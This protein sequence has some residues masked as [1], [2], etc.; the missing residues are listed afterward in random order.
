MCKTQINF[1]SSWN[2][3]HGK[4]KL[5]TWELLLA[6]F[7]DLAYF[8]SIYLLIKKL[9]LWTRSQNL[10]SNLQWFYEFCDVSIPSQIIPNR[11]WSSLTVLD[12]SE[13]N[14]HGQFAQNLMKRFQKWKNHCNKW[15]F[16]EFKEVI[17]LWNKKLIVLE[18]SCLK[19]F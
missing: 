16:E 10:K 1:I 7:Y 17:W 3:F 9:I 4:F 18:I 8:D 15:F 6:C 11:S 2:V 19:I 5:F 14:G 13:H 12:G